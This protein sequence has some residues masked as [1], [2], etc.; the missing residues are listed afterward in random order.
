LGL[1]AA[2]IE[3]ARNVLNLKGAHSTE[4]NPETEH[5][6]VIDM[7]EHHPG[8]MGGTMRLGKRT[9]IFRDESSILSKSFI[10]KYIVYSYP[11]YTLTCQLVDKFSERLYGST[12]QI[13][14]R[15]RHRYEVNPKYV[16][17]LEAAGLKFVGKT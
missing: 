10:Y 13:E 9:T 12:K 2:V 4:V 6:L 15:H 17:D 14:E 8:Q 11:L 3:Y 7:P 16:K 5:P 1:Q